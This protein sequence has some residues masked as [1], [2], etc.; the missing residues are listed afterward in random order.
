MGEQ[1]GRALGLQL[2]GSLMSEG[3]SFLALVFLRLS[4]LV[5]WEKLS[6]LGWSLYV[7]YTHSHLLPIKC[8]LKKGKEN[9]I[10]RTVEVKCNRVC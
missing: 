3:N 8:L 2:T 4:W 1:S 7:Q 5:S 6:N 10:V 9:D